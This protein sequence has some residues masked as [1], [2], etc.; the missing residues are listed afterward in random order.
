MRIVGYSSIDR[1]LV[2]SPDQIIDM[3]SELALMLTG[4]GCAGR[5]DG[6]AHL[7]CDSPET[8]Y[9]VRCAERADACT[10]CR[11]KC[12]KSK[13]NCMIDHSVY[14]AVFA[15][16][17]MKVGVSRSYRLE[18]RLMEQGADEGYEI[19]RF[20][21]GESARALER[22]LSARFPDRLSFAEKLG[23]GVINR[24]AVGTALNGFDIFRTYTFNHFPYALTSSP[25]PIRPQVNMGISGRVVGIKGQALVLKKHDT[26]YAVNLDSLVGFDCCEERKMKGHI[27]VSLAGF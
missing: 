5:W 3:S 26:F 16:S 13:K 27:Q 1:V 11:G 9:C 10:I 8:P 6:T 14:L 2:V 4:R 22:A 24:A 23:T 17:T 21:D 20:P 12:L 25:I 15:P 19:A 7:P 18:T